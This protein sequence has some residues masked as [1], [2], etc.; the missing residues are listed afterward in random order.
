[1]GLRRTHGHEKHNDTRAFIDSKELS[2]CFS[3]ESPTIRELLGLLRL[4]PSLGLMG[5]ASLMIEGYWFR[6]WCL[7]ED[8]SEPNV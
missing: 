3:S 8:E 6:F 7:P 2:K 1:M 5:M 4:G